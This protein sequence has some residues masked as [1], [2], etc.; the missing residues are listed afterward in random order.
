MTN[1]Y[2]ALS[3]F[4]EEIIYDENYKNWMQF[5]LNTVKANALGVKGLDVACGTGILTRLLKKNGFDIVGVDV[6]QDM[7]NVAQQKSYQE[8]LNIQYLKGD[9]KSFKALERVDFITVINDGLNYL[10]SKFLEKTFKNFYNS[11]KKG[12]VLIFDVS[13]PYKLKNILGNN[14]FGDDGE[15]LSYL[16]LNNFNEESSSVEISLSIFEKCGNVYKRYTETQIQYAHT[17]ETLLK[18]LKEVGFSLVSVTDD[19]GNPLKED[20][21]RILFI[22]KK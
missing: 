8:K 5:I 12:G 15:N 9:M 7:L 6:S 2:T 11:L 18:N 16:W 1:E 21:E 4:Y 22:L 20:S 19:F 17:K 14:A 13:S 10:E 3:K